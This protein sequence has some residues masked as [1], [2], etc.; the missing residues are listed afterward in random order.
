M[1]NRG[2]GFDVRRDP[3]VEQIGHASRGT[4]CQ[5]RVECGCAG[6]HRATGKVVAF[7]QLDV[8]AVGN[9]GLMEVMVDV[10]AK[11]PCSGPAE[12]CASRQEGYAA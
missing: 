3:I 2:A 10:A 1:C 12:R 4:G 9:I 7:G 5:A 6:I 11:H 8:H